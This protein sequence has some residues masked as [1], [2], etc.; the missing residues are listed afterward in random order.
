MMGIGDEYYNRF[1]TML[2]NALMSGR[3]RFSEHILYRYEDM[4]VYRGVKYGKNKVKIDKTDFYS[5]AERELPGYNLDDIN[6]YGCSCFEDL[7]E[8]HMI[9]KFPTKN[10]AI[11][12][13]W[14]KD[15]YGPCER[16]L[17]NTH[18][19]LFIYDNVDI[20][21]EFE[22]CEKWEENGLI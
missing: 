11:A 7:E 10:K 17:E 6:T 14:I 21:G 13:G 1:P 12:K 16:S 15:Q 5:H 19:N 4:L 9:T 8:L 22:V 3:V 18:V 20:S 2:R